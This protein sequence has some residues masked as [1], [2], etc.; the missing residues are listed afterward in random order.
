MTLI[1]LEN[2]SA[3]DLKA[4]ENKLDMAKAAPHDELAA[5]YCRAL[6]DAKARDEKLAEQGRTINALNDAL[7]EAKQKAADAEARCQQA[8]SAGDHAVVTLRDQIATLKFKLEETEK[9]ARQLTGDI[10]A[11]RARAEA[12]EAL[13][14]ARRTA[15][16]DVMNF[17]GQLS[18]KVAPLLAE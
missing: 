15:L 2:L 17:A 11:Q 9:A 4:L 10:D 7:G 13:A 1:D 3:G 8:V 14:K 5:R 12:A 6:Y 18:G 16:A